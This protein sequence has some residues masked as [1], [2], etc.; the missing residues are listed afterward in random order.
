MRGAYVAGLRRYREARAN[1]RACIREGR[2]ANAKRCMAADKTRKDDYLRLR[3]AHRLLV[4]AYAVYRNA[5]ALSSRV[6]L[7]TSISTLKEWLTHE[8]ID[9]R[10]TGR[11]EHRFKSA[12]AGVRS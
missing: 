7:R 9:L 8:I 1:V 4:E 12:V 10:S 6:T 2:H 3:T 11:E 5:K